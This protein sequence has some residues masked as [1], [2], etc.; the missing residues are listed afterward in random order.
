MTEPT[1]SEGFLHPNLQAVANSPQLRPCVRFAAKIAQR[2]TVSL[3][4]FL[5]ELPDEHLTNLLS[6]GVDAVQDKEDSLT[7]ITLVAVMVATAEGLMIEAQENVST[8]A[9]RLMMAL[10]AERSRRRGWVTFDP[11]K[12][13]LE[14]M[15]KRQ[16]TLTELGKQQFLRPLP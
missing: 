3:G 10:S 14:H 11:K 16:F 12:L 15:E 5:A 4:T 1:P 6:L 9:E 13:T 8:Y 7:Q 2:G